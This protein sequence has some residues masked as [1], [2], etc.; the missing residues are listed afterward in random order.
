MLTTVYGVWCSGSTLASGHSR[1]MPAATIGCS[2]PG[3]L[4]LVPDAPSAGAEG[5][6]VWNVILIGKHTRSRNT[7]NIKSIL[8][9]ST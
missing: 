5:T 7:C 9:G 3:D 8:S 2:N 4:L 6:V 1:A